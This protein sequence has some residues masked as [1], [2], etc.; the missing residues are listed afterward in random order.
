MIK[1]RLARRGRKRLAIYD[2]VVANSRSPRDGRFIE[3]LGVYNPNTVPASITLDPER[4]LYWA[5]NGAQLTPTSRAILSYK[6]ILYKKHLQVGVNKGAITQEQADE[7]FN[8]WQTKKTAQIDNRIG[9]LEG[10]K[11]ADKK[12]RLEAESKINQARADALREKKE[13]ENAAKAEVQKAKADAEKAA[14]DAIRAEKEPKVEV[15]AET[16]T[17]VVAETVAEV[18]P[19]V[20]PTAE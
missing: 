1:I 5:M 9:N 15:V 6:G 8:A 18:Q 13:A 4:A 16:V 12:A 7:K 3:K 11:D 10:L 19:D 14:A 20:T 17:E 2:I